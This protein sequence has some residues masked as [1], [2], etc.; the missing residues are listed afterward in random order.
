MNNKLINDDCLHILSKLKDNSIDHCITDPPYNISGYDGKK[1]IGWYKSNK[2]WKEDKQFNKISEEWDSFTDDDYLELVD[3]ANITPRQKIRKEYFNN[4]F[5][6][7]N[8]TYSQK[9][10]DF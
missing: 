9:N 2:T 6:K 1:E 7:V 4:D 8:P 3:L 10:L 5:L